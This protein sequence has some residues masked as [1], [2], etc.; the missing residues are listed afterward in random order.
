VVN[1][2]TRRYSNA[3]RLAVGLSL[4]LASKV[5]SARKVNGRDFCIATLTWKNSTVLLVGKLQVGWT[6]G[7]ALTV[8]YDG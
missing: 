8:A 5:L 2:L 1:Q 6:N 3:V 7:A 4:L